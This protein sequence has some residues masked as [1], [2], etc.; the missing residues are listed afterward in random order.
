VRASAGA[1]DAVARP[2]VVLVHGLSASGVSHWPLLPHLG[3]A[4]VRLVLPDLAGHG[5]SERRP[6]LG[7]DAIRA[8]L[9]EALERVLEEPAVLVGNSLGGFAALTVALERPHLVRGLVLTSPGG[10]RVEEHE[11]TELRRLFAAARHA[12]ALEFLDRLVA[13]PDRRTRHL[14]A[15]LIRRRFRRP[16]V[17][18]LL[19]AVQGGSG[20]PPEELRR[21]DKPA[22]VV[23]GARDRILPRRHLDWYREH[24][25]AHVE[26]ET[27]SH[28][29]HTPFLDDPRAL[30]ARILRFVDDRI[31]RAPRSADR[32]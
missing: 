5:F 1:A 7:P 15:W 26:F 16:E 12:D 31:V 25:P 28:F 8:G 18:A 11:L 4:G 3:R 23:W 22:L 27:P 21:L 6:D 19:R 32:A 13:R 29:G 20:I 24:M 2:P 17:A 9:G 14:V 30:A 10:A